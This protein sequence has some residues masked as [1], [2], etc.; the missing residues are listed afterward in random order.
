MAR[1]KNSFEFSSQ[2]M[3]HVGGASKSNLAEVIKSLG[4]GTATSG[5]DDPMVKN[6][7]KENIQEV[8]KKKYGIEV[9]TE[10]IKNAGGGGTKG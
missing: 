9:D 2:P 8:L 3:G 4:G 6:K 1:L 5:R 10:E 7:V